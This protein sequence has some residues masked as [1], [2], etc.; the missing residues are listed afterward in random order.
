MMALPGVQCF[1][2]QRGSVLS[3]VFRGS[4]SRKDWIT[5]LT[6]FKKAIPY[7]NPASRIRVHSG[8]INAY[9]A[10]QVRCRL[11][12]LISPQIRKVMICGH[13]YGAGSG[14]ALCR[15]SSV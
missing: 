12:Q 14:C 13:S 3:I 10:P 15:R 7:D 4:D 9:K 8:F 2:R 6:F 1:V 11:Q 5:D